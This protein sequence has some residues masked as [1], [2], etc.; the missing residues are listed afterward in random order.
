MGHSLKFSWPFGSLVLS[1][2]SGQIPAGCSA[3]DDVSVP[4]K[5]AGKSGFLCFS[6]T[7]GLVDA[8]ASVEVSV[9]F[10]SI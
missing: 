9:G 8:F 6:L 7:Q 10:L 2:A 1:V 3:V 5:V 4:Q